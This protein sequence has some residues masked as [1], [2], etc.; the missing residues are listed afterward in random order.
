[1]NYCEIEK[2]LSEFHKNIFLGLDSILK[3]V[4]ILN[5]SL[6]S[7][8]YIHVAGTNGKGSCVYKLSSVLKEAG[9]LV[10]SFY[11]PH[12]NTFRERICLDGQMISKS[13]FES[14]FVEVFF[15]IK[16]A[17]IDLTFF[18][19]MTLIALYFF[20][21]E[22]VDVAI[23][24]V[25]LGG[26]FDATNIITPI[27]SVI[28]SIHYDHQPILGNTLDEIGKEKAGIIKPGIPVVL[29]PCAQLDSIVQEAKKKN[30]PIFRVEGDYVDYVE[31]NNILAKTVCEK[32]LIHRFK[33]DLKKAYD[34]IQNRNPPLRFQV[35]QYENK[36]CVFDV[37]H[38]PDGLQHLFAKLKNA[39]PKKKL[40]GVCGFSKQQYLKQELDI[41][42][43]QLEA[44]YF[45][46]GKKY[47]RL[48]DQN[49]IIEH[50]NL[51]AIEKVREPKITFYDEA[52]TGFLDAVQ[53]SSK[54][55]I[56]VVFG[57]FFFMSDI[58]QLFSSGVVRD[59]QLL[60]EII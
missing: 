37:G 6:N 50:L 47:L 31:E 4:S 42:L 11:S 20:V 45:V 24:E 32:V 8:P 60:M 5:I 44:V 55:E 7:I 56:I 48:V 38:N 46:T 13:Q 9:Y 26:R 10:G 1:M 27:V 40:R 35:Y 36:V 39:Y 17:N 19:W 29:G 52:S 16:K 14:V 15:R 25:G 59:K 23:L 33:L 49:T 3:A 53:E 41:V 51:R 57:S 30:S 43:P 2:I 12:I 34:V 58:L 18:E 54:E 21:K 22:K 28:T